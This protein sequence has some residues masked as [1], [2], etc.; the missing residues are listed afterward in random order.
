MSLATDYGRDYALQ[1]LERRRE[2]NRNI[3]KENNADLPPGAPKY[4]YCDSCN[5]EMKLPGNHTRPAP[6]LCSECQALKGAG[7]L[8]EVEEQV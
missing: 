8:D 4:Y 1:E 2:W 3:K 7:L 5:E 6:S